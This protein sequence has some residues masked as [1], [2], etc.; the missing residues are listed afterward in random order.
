MDGERLQAMFEKF[1]EDHHTFE[2]IPV[3]DRLHPSRRLC[4]F[5][6][7]ASLMDDPSDFNLSAEHDEIWI[8]DADDLRDDTTEDDI[9]YLARCGVRYDSEVDSLAMFC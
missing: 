2:K 3:A 9:R 4:A 7:I 8:A 6:K 5:L 1:E